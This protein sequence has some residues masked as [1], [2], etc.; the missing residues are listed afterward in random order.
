LEASIRTAAELDVLMEDLEPFQ[1]EVIVNEIGEKVGPL[2][3]LA[4]N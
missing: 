2:S 1:E 4:E 3:E